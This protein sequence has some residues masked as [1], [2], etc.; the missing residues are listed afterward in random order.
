M[1]VGIV[2]M[3]GGIMGKLPEDRVKAVVRKL[4]KESPQL[5]DLDAETLD[6]LG[7]VVTAAALR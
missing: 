1:D 6:K 2:S 5:A 4:A 3:A 7:R